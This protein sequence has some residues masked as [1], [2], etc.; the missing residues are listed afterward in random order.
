MIQ[1][2]G[3]QGMGDTLLLRSNIVSSQVMGRSL[4]PRRH[5]F[6]IT[7]RGN[8]TISRLMPMIRTGRVTMGRLRLLRLKQLIR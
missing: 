5:R 7:G 1:A 6:L 4:A 8:G 2:T 3:S